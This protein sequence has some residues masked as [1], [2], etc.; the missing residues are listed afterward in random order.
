M[1]ARSRTTRSTSKASRTAILLSSNSHLTA[2]PSTPSSSC[3]MSQ[4]SELA[5]NT[6]MEDFEHLQY[7]HTNLQEEYDDMK[8]R[9]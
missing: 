5:S 7:L 6:I 3:E 9:I 4:D 1:R 8:S 2:T